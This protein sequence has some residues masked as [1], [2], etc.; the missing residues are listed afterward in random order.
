MPSDAE[1][2]KVAI[3]DLNNSSISFEGRLRALED[4]L[5]LVE[6]IDNANGM[7]FIPQPVPLSSVR[8]TRNAEIIAF[9]VPSFNNE[10]PTPQKRDLSSIL[11]LIF[12]QLF[13]LPYSNVT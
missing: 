5:N 9:F 4:L 1:L 11:C 8:C 3:N 2:M 7:Y 10:A 6:S 13:L 12:Y